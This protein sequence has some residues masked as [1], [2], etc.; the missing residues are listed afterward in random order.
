LRGTVAIF[1][2]AR[3]GRRR[4]AQK[5]FPFTIHTPDTLCEAAT[6]RACHTHGISS[7]GDTLPIWKVSSQSVKSHPRSWHIGSHLIRSG[8]ASARLQPTG[9]GRDTP[10]SSSKRGFR[11]RETVAVNP[12]SVRPNCRADVRSHG[13]SV[14]D[15]G[16]CPVRNRACPR[17]VRDRLCVRKLSAVSPCP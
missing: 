6:G 17:P 10:Y 13:Q 3:A 7:A 16:S 5:I 12:Q 1:S 15:P 14:S 8:L 4:D 2:H 11:V 9:F